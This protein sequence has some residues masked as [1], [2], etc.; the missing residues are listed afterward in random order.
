MHLA[1]PCYR[2]VLNND[3]NLTDGAMLAVLAALKDLRLP[4]MSAISEDDTD[5]PHIVNPRQHPLTLGPLPIA[6]SYGFWE[7]KVL[8]DP[9]G[10]EETLIGS[11]ITTAVWVDGTIHAVSKP[12]PSTQQQAICTTTVSGERMQECVQR[13]TERAVEVVKLIDAALANQG[14]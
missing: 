5:L 13:A 11:S 6:V 8:A 3:G 4:Q 14:N 9:T 7:D 2:Y 10:A 1:L 12:S